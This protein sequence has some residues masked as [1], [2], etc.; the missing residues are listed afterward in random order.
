MTIPS[1]QNIR[2]M[3]LVTALLIA[4]IALLVNLGLVVPLQTPTPTPTPG[5]VNNPAQQVM[6]GD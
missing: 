3:I 6:R 1:G 4:V 2:L 5:I